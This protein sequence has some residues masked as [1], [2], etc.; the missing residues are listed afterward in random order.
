MITLNNEYS[1]DIIPNKSYFEIESWKT[2]AT[3]ILKRYGIDIINKNVDTGTWLYE[4]YQD[5]QV[6]WIM[7]NG[8]ESCI[9]NIVLDDVCDTSFSDLSFHIKR[10]TND[11]IT[12]VL[13]LF[14]NDSLVASI[15]LTPE[16]ICDISNL[17]FEVYE[18]IDSTGNMGEELTNDYGYI[19]L[20]KY[21][22]LIKEE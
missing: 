2:S 13:Q 8:Y 5:L 19:E 14:V 21:Y 12:V 4:L 1:L 9:Y 17:I 10:T 3:F 20:E 11:R 22:D 7:V 18:S 16:M 6:G 15:Q